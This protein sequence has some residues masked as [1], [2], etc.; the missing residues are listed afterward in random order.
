MNFY[1]GDKVK[2][3]KGTFENYY[4]IIKEKN[5]RDLFKYKLKIDN[6]INY[7]SDGS[8][9]ELVMNN[10]EK[11]TIY[12]NIHTSTSNNTTITIN[13]TIKH[14]KHYT[15]G[16]IETWD[17]I[18][19]HNLNFLE[20]SVIKYVTRHRHK[21]GIEDLKKAREFINKLIEVEEKK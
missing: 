20:G 6:V 5:T 7:S 21:N 12:E 11:P 2:I 13:D 3:T 8:D 15:Q 18:I 10:F 19:D 9:M 4:G 16:K 17:F 14:P 1:V